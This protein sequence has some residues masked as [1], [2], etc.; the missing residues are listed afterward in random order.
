MPEVNWIIDRGKR[1]PHRGSIMSKA[2]EKQALSISN[3][4][5]K[6]Q[7]HQRLIH[8]G[9]RSLR[10]SGGGWWEWNH[11]VPGTT[12]QFSSLSLEHLKGFRRAEVRFSS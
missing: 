2:S 12:I 5:M 10:H 3:E 11:T 9:T 8:Q 7:E 1:I 6:V 4:L